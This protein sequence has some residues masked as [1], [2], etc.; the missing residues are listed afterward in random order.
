[1]SKTVS[2]ID[3][4]LN[5]DENSL[6][7]TSYLYGYTPYGI[8]FREI[9]NSYKKDLIKA[10]MTLLLF[11]IDII[12]DMVLLFYYYHRDSSYFKMTLIVC[13]LPSFI[14]IVSLVIF[15]FMLLVFNKERMEK[16][17]KKKYNLTFCKAMTYIILVGLFSTFQLHVIFM[18]VLK[19]FY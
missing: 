9:K 18:L 2:V 1:M 15:V 4:T 8:K 16:K 11:Y 17:V 12:S 13:C 10:F 3:M 6:K 7:Q 5:S 19:N 14:L